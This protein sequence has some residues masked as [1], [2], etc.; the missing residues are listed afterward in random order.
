MKIHGQ[1]QQQQIIQESNKKDSSE[2]VDNHSKDDD[3][4]QMIQRAVVFIEECKALASNYEW[5]ILSS[6][7]QDP[8]LHSKLETACGI[9]KRADAF[10]SSDTQE[11]VGFDWARC[12]HV[13]STIS[14]LDT[15]SRLSRSENLILN[16]SL[17][18]IRKQLRMAPLR[19]L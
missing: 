17:K 2:D 14:I 18:K 1:Q 12:V 9:L 19:S 11:I 5:E 15:S 8:I 10:L 13:E 6:S 4:E 3:S 7:L 16:C